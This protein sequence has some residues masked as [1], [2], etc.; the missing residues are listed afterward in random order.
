M[1]T[2]KTLAFITGATQG[3]G[4]ATARALAREHNFH[5][6]IGAR[7]L[8]EGDKVASEL[9]SEGHAADTVHIDLT[10]E[11]SIN[12]AV[13]AIERE[14]GYLD[15]LVNNA[16]ILYDRREGMRK[17]DLWSQTMLTN[18]IGTGVLTEGLLPLLRK[19]RSGPPRIVFLSSIMGSIAMTQDPSVPWHSIDYKAY[20]ASKAAVNMAMLNFAQALEKEGGKVNSVCPGYI[21][22]A[23]TGFDANGNTPEQGAE[24]VVAMATLGADG[25]TGTFSNKA[26]L[27]PF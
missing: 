6:L 10:S 14:H 7:K 19:S 4:R 11:A 2:A 26:G 1:S 20:D 5:V 23:L 9:R 13:A 25:P 8:E 22:T 21:S 24:H 12:D 18:V 15:V 27:L 3:V 16:G 17:W